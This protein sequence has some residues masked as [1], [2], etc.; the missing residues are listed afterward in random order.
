MKT[1]GTL[2]ERWAHGITPQINM[3]PDATISDYS[4]AKSAKSAQDAAEV[5][6][7]LTANEDKS[8]HLWM[9]WLKT[10]KSVLSLANESRH[11]ATFMKRKK[12]GITESQ[13]KKDK[14]DTNT[15]ERQGN[16]A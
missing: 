5:E 12:S 16:A 11:V 7:K 10:C 1:P 8:N 9:N 14:A 6:L 4:K 3:R 13:W 2:A 15:W